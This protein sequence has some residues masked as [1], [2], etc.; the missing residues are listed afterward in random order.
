MNTFIRL[1][2]S[3]E[4]TEQDI[5]P[6]CVIP[7]INFKPNEQDYATVRQWSKPSINEITQKVVKAPPAL[8]DGIW[9]QQWQVIEIY[10]TQAEVDAAIAADVEVKRV[11]AVPTT[12]SPRQIRQAL[13]RAGLRTAVEAAVAVGDQDTKDWYEFATEFHRA[14]PVVAALSVA[15]NVDGEAL[16]GLWTLAASL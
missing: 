9:T 1:S 3:L 13:S 5:D 8:V 7:N 12:V 10:A 6:L 11:A 14:S 4:M 16:D 2:D 15:L